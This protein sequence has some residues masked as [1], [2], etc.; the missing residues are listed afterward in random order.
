MLCEY[1]YVLNSYY[2][3]TDNENWVIIVH[4]NREP[5]MGERYLRDF[6]IKKNS[7]KFSTQA[8]INNR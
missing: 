6:N 1:V 4:L 7:I 5:P 2:I 8:F 3:G